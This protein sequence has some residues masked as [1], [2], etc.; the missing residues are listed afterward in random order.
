MDLLLGIHFNQFGFLDELRLDRFHETD[1]I[2]I[3]DR[4]S[5]FLSVRFSPEQYTSLYRTFGVRNG[6]YLTTTQW[7]DWIARLFGRHTYITKTVTQHVD[8]FNSQIWLEFQRI[9]AFYDIGGKGY[10][11]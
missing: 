6:G 4:L 2:R 1:F 3:I 8:E 5:S 7:E 9:F 10:L 11:T